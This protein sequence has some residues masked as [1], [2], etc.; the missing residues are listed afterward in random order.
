MAFLCLTAMIS[1]DSGIL[2]ECRVFLE[3][4]MALRVLAVASV[5]ADVTSKRHS[6][7][8]VLKAREQADVTWKKHA[9]G[10]SS[11]QGS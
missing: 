8:H 10:L 3:P 2:M 9:K 5:L 11:K 6:K 4:S 7:G 1:R